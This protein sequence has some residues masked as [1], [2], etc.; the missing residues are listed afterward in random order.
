MSQL[1]DAAGNPV[2]TD[3]VSQLQAVAALNAQVLLQLRGQSTCTIQVT[4]IGTQTLVFEGSTDGVNFYALT[5]FP[6]GGFTGAP[7]TST[8]ATGQWV[9]VCAGMYQVRVRCSAYTSGSA[10]VSMVAAQGTNEQQVTT[11]I[12]QA[13]VTAGQLNQLVAGAVTTAA[14]AYT[15]AQ[16]NPISLTVAGGLRTDQS[17]QGA[18][19]I[20]SVPVA[21][22]SGVLTGNAPV[23]NAAMY[24]GTAAVAASAIAGVPKSDNSS[25]AG[26]AIT[27][28]PVAAGS[29]ALTGNAPVVNAALY[30]ATTAAVASSAGVQKVGI[31]GGVAG[32]AI[33][34]AIAAAPPANALQIGIKAATANP[35][36]ATAGNQVA[37]MGDKAGRPV[38]TAGNVREL[39][40]VQTTVITASVAE[41]T[42]ITAGGAGVFNDLSHISITTTDVVAAVITIKDATA[43]TTRLTFEYPPTAAAVGPLTCDFAIPIPQA[44][45]ANNWTATVSV[46][47]GAVAI[48]CVFVKN[49]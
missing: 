36:N 21:A 14:P 22:G 46:N 17:S 44:A 29:G 48:N 38:V 8:T 2:L 18:T 30:V 19:A 47:A 39:I 32:A 25:Q 33:D 10:T 15:T 3:V 6:I 4:A 16:T 24:V 37:I 43:G 20:T 9:F 40:G 27:S 5:V 1:Y 45:A 35:A 11:G 34:G 41:T 42:I 13:A 49:T 28:V 31:A 23:V 12:A 26:T 7:I